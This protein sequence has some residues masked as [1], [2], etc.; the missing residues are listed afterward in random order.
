MVISISVYNT[1]MSHPG[2]RGIHKKASRRDLERTLLDML[3]MSEA[4][5][6]DC[7]SIVEDEASYE[8]LV[9]MI[10]NLENGLT[11]PEVIIGSYGY[12]F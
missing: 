6:L 7:Q 5:F 8:E 11:T 10:W 9:E 2:K 1:D 12:T 3:T 4:D